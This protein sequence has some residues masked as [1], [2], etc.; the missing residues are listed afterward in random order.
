MFGVQVRG[1]WVH[2]V[3]DH[4]PD[5][6]DS[7]EREKSNDN[8]KDGANDLVHHDSLPFFVPL[9]TESCA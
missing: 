9:A 2:F 8:R 4:F 5:E 7:P 1:K 6:H 3:S